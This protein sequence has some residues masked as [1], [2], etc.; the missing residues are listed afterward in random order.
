VGFLAE[1][2]LNYQKEAIPNRNLVFRRKVLEREGVLAKGIFKSVAYCLLSLLL[3][4]FGFPGAIHPSGAAALL[5]SPRQHHYL[6]LAMLIGVVAGLFMVHPIREAVLIAVTLVI[7]YGITG[8]FYGRRSGVKPLISFTIWAVLRVAAVAVLAPDW[9][10]YLMVAAEL[11]LTYVLMRIFKYGL[12]FINNPVKTHSKVAMAGLTLLIVLAVGGIGDLTVQSV[13][14]Q[15]IVTPL[16]LLIVSF[17]GGGG[18]GA[19]MGIA[20]AIIVGIG[21]GLA[22]LVAVYGIGGLLG[23][24]LKDL[25]RWGTAAGTAFGWYFALQQLQP[26]AA[27]TFQIWP[28]GLGAAVFLLIPRRYLSLLA[29][30]FPN[31]E[32]GTF[33]QDERQKLREVVLSRLDDL[34]GI[35]EELAR[36]FNQNEAV[37]EAEEKVDLYSLLDRVCV[38]NCKQCSGYDACWGENFYSTYREIFDLLALAELYGEVHVGHLKGKLAKTCFQQFKL[39]TTINH[40]FERCQNE[41]QWQRKLDEG[42]YFLANQLQGM[43]DIIC[44]LSK[45][46]STDTNFK[47]EVE[48]RLKH[49]FNRLN[50]SIR[51]VSVLSIGGERLEI[52][53]RQ[54]S[55]NHKHE[56]AYLAAPMVSK[57]LGAE[58]LVW[59]RQC[60][61]END[62][63][64]YCLSPVRK[65]AVKTSVCKLPKQGNEYSGDNNSLQELKDGHFVAILSDGMGY[66]TKAYLESQTTV[67]IL[68][69]LLESGIDRD[70]AVKMVN[71][72][73]L[74]RSPEESFATVDLVL[75]DLFDGQ[76]EFIKIG[77]AS[78]YLKRGP[79]VISIK[80]TSLPAGILNTVDAERTEMHLQPGDLI[81]LASDGV[82]DSKENPPGKDDWVV[83][84]L[85]Q[86][87]VVGPEALG[88]YLMSLAKI[89]Y[90]GVP[91]DDMSV[92][93]LQ[94]VENSSE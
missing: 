24:A 91:K 61:L 23:G 46:I 8:F 19:V 88:E 38:K 67:S 22:G 11:A 65:F 31:Q 42:K 87:D 84:A 83:R 81:V 48:E 49:G 70:F 59:E 4:R 44:N 16:L 13:R 1:L 64:G 35:F 80:S 56:C 94:F 93:V 6:N 51:D 58:Y 71:S 57:L 41:Y 20:V 60:H 89:N 3:T 15:D 10:A 63:C 75:I 69:K 50:M 45:E 52:T 55:C 2:T 34:A 82:I 53:V 92:V 30:Y 54:R 66:G 78:S 27:D 29:A 32:S 85:R 18:V 25:G 47:A 39:L 43:A 26:A 62:Q 73:L 76:A 40:L 72:V 36:S 21:G 77:A 7:W 37:A 79:D 9:F 5:A 12:I 28:L 17:L 90:D 68:E 14:L 33:H 86:V 74:L